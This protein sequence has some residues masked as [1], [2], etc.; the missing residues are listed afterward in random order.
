MHIQRWRGMQGNL[1][2]CDGK[3]E[4]LGD[5]QGRQLLTGIILE[6]WSPK[7][8]KSKTERQTD[9]QTCLTEVKVGEAKKEQR[10]QGCSEE[11]EGRRQRREGGSVQQGGAR[12]GRG[13]YIFFMILFNL[14][15]LTAESVPSQVLL[16]GGCAQKADRVKLLP[17]LPPGS[18][19]APTWGDLIPLPGYDLPLC[20]PL[21]RCCN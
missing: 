16:G 21:P 8:V 6:H 9:R 13:I 11:G 14:T 5:L 10:K 20:L 12:P 4:P 19:P 17:Q 1:G 15:R 7:Y 18:L 3:R 2:R